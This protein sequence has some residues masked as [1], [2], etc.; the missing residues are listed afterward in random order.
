MT[1]S[2]KQDKMLAIWG[3]RERG[4]TE[5]RIEKLLG[6]PSWILSG[7]GDGSKRAYHAHY[8]EAVEAGDQFRE[9]FKA[10][11]KRRRLDK[12]FVQEVL[13]RSVELENSGAI[14]R[15]LEE[16]EAARIA[17]EEE[18]AVRAR[19]YKDKLARSKPSIPRPPS[20]LLCCIDVDVMSEEY[21]VEIRFM[22]NQGVD[23]V[24]CEDFPAATAQREYEGDSSDSISILLP[25]VISVIMRYAGPVNFSRAGRVTEKE[26]TE[27]V[28]D[29]VMRSEKIR[30]ANL[31]QSV[32]EIVSSAF[33]L[34]L[35]PEPSS[36]SENLWAA[37]C[38]AARH[39]MLLNT[40]RNE[41]WC[42]YCKR[43]GDVEALRSYSEEH[44]L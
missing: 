5:G 20:E 7:W 11:A 39:R 8:V 16:K 31:E 15:W 40:S 10:S 18:A 22:R 27:I 35:Q 32:A 19:L 37:N 42:G 3:I 41:F 14:A 29:L 24:F 4:W 30:K 1:T 9:A 36:Q 23:R 13:S 21:S 28:N 12:E 44:K 43:S 34:G 17:R 25:V 26:F 38:P 33:A 6:E 2:D